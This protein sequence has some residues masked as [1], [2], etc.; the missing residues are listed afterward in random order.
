M[1]QK[2]TTPGSMIGLVVSVWL[3]D[4]RLEPEVLFQRLN[5]HAADFRR[6]AAEMKQ[7]LA[8]LEQLPGDHPDWAARREEAWS[9]RRE[10]AEQNGEALPER[11]SDNPTIRDAEDQLDLASLRTT[12]QGFTEQADLADRIVALPDSPNID[13]IGMRNLII[14]LVIQ[15]Q[16][17]EPQ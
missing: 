15:E 17:E 6:G 1:K 9:I 2:L 14:D 4:D 7:Q 10:L 8:R 12:I 3:D 11:P 13:R 16:S 5:R